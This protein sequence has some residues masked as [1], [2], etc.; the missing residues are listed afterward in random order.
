MIRQSVNRL[1]PRSTLKCCRLLP[2]TAKPCVRMFATKP[3]PLNRSRQIFK[4]TID[5]L[6]VNLTVIWTPLKSFCYLGGAYGVFCVG[7]STL[8]PSEWN[9][10]DHNVMLTGIVRF[11]RT[12]SYAALIM[13]VYK[14]SYWGVVKPEQSDENP[15]GKPNGKNVEE[16][17]LTPEQQKYK[18]IQHKFWEFAANRIANVM[19]VNGGSYIK[20]GQGMATY[21]SMLPPEFAAALKPLLSNIFE[22]QSGEI[23][24]MFVEDLGAQP[25]NLY[26]NFKRDPIAGASIAQVFLGQTHCGKKVAIKVQ[27]FDIAKRFKMD[28]G[29]CL[30]LLRVLDWFI[31]GIPFLNVMPHVF[32][33]LKKELDFV[34]EGRNSDLCK[35]E[36]KDLDFMYVPAVHWK[37]TSKRILTMDFAE[38]I[39][40]TD[41]EKIKA[42]GFDA[43]EIMTKVI[44]IFSEQIFRTGNIHSDPHPG[45]LMVRKNH[46]T[47]KTEI[48]VI[49]HGLYEHLPTE[50]RQAF[51][52]FWHSVIIDDHDEVQ[53]SGKILG[54]NFPDMMAT[55][56]FFQPYGKMKELGFGG[57][58]G[59]RRKKVEDMNEEEKEQMEAIRHMAH[60]TL[61]TLPKELA[62][63][64]RNLRLIQGI[65]L[66]FGVPINR[67][68]LM[69]EVAV[70]NS[71]KDEDFFTNLQSRAKFEWHFFVL[72]LRNRLIAWALWLYSRFAK[73][74]EGAVDVSQAALFLKA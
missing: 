38:G 12:V 18:E 40:L 26:A 24:H 61:D 25:E 66:S 67:V 60:D 55:L 36:L 21:S 37:L 11:V 63:V 7:Y 9:L 70:K 71:K 32:D 49:D 46:R 65:N 22:R 43:K 29:T 41:A 47:G 54:L 28:K 69:A 31:P 73:R 10:S 62:L 34:T 39:S 72:D 52:S 64:F 19:L 44:R 50:Y 20:I 68:R 58:H 5:F 59:E 53:R 74:V 14:Y 13:A 57:M 4:Y 1:Q 51:A 42:A 45:N 6:K 30:F 8:S 33:S 27:Y 35:N 17:E 15:F 48:V 16:V 2:R 3:Y 56:L 23:E